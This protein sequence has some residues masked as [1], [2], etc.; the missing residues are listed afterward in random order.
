MGQIPPRS[1][2]VGTFYR[3][4]AAR[5]RQSA[6]SGAG[7]AADVAGPRRNPAWKSGVA[8][9]GGVEGTRGVG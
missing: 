1:G 4:M 6:F 5:V 2:P 3:R 9:S 8:R 7:P